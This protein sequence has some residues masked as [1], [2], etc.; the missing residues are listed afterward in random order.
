MTPE[1]TLPKSVNKQYFLLFQVAQQNW[2]L[3]LQEE[4]LKRKMCKHRVARQALH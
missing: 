3:V 2:L 1:T 4:K